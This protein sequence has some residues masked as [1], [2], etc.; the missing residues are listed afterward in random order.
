MPA[1][2]VDDLISMLSTARFVGGHKVS[3]TS[4]AAG[5]AHS[6]W[7]VEGTPRAGATPATGTGA[8]P[9]KATTGAMA[10]QN[11]ASLF[12]ARLMRFLAVGSV[13]GQLVLYDRLW[14]N[15]GLSGSSTSGQTVNSVALDRPDA[16][17][18]GAELWGEVYT[19]IGS[20]TNYTIT[21]TYTN[22]GGTGSRSAVFDQSTYSSGGLNLAGAMFPF[23]LQAGDTGIKSVQ[24]AILSA[25]SGAAGDWGLTI[26]RRVATLTL[27][28]ANSGR[29]LD[30]F[31]TAL[32]QIYD[33]ACLAL[34]VIPS[35]TTTGLI[36]WNTLV[37][38]DSE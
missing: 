27:D 1:A 20:N 15:S 24:S 23:K 17:G 30:L 31:R 4:K 36:H 12:N 6:L 22:P 8:I 9:T 26:L 25:T 34:M 21:A 37:G 28:V 19:A 32:A 10:H 16:L 29:E 7:K 18:E 3:A 2:S 11:A 13:V 38:E 35:T 14:H 33:D 5:I